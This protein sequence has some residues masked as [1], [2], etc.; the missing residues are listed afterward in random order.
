MSTTWLRYK[1]SEQSSL[2]DA[3]RAYAVLDSFTEQDDGN[4]AQVYVDNDSNL[5]RIATFQTARMERLFKAFPEVV[6]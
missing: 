2:N 4:M 5:A 6:L 1:I 3:Q